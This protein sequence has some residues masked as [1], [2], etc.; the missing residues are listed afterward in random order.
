MHINLCVYN[1]CILM[2]NR[3]VISK[4]KCGKSLNSASVLNKTFFILTGL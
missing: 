1:L 4:K 2:P 3:P